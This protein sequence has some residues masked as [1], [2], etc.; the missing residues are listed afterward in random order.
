MGVSLYM[1]III[2]CGGGVKEEPGMRQHFDVGRPQVAMDKP[3]AAA[4]HG[5]A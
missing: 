1:H 5:E 4:M 3:L 2:I